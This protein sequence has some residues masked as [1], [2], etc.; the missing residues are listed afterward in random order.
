MA[1]YKKNL[2]TVGGN[3]SGRESL[4]EAS[5]S[6]FFAYY[7]NLEKK[8]A[9]EIMERKNG[10]FIWSV[11]ESNLFEDLNGHSLLT[12]PPSEITEEYVL[13][14]GGL[15]RSHNKAVS[16]FNGKS[17]A[18]FKFNGKWSFFGKLNRSRS[19]HN[20]IYWNGA[21]YVIGGRIVNHS[22]WLQETKMEIWKIADSPSEF[23]T[24]ENC[25]E[26]Y[27]WIDPHLFIVS[28][29]IFPDY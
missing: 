21:V 2:V 22:T 8:E 14:I 6:D 26:L 24:T 20:A 13:L 16:N 15:V 28:D 5:T 18:I 19:D 3:D 4:P 27:D 12:I 23:K 7:S 25:P 11:V 1:K 9:T 17:D 10:T 29:S